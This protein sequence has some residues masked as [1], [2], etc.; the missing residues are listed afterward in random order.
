M[1]ELN[2]LNLS[3]FQE[4]YYEATFTEAAAAGKSAA[5]R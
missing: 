5:V 1:V 4:A 3:T 2:I